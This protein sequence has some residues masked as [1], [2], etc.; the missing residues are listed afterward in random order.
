VP[1]GLWPAVL[2]A[3]VIVAGAAGTAVGWSME[4]VARGLAGAGAAALLFPVWHRT[5]RSW[6]R[7]LRGAGGG[8]LA[9]AQ[10]AV[11]RACCAVPG[12]SPSD[13]R[14]QGGPPRRPPLLRPAWGT[15]A[16]RGQGRF[17]GAWWLDAPAAAPSRRPALQGLG[18]T[19]GLGALLVALALAPAVARWSAVQGM[20][21]AGALLPAGFEVHLTLAEQLRLGA[22]VPARWPPEA[23]VPLAGQAA[24]VDAAALAQAPRG[25]PLLLAAAGSLTGW[26]AL[27]LFWPL[28]LVVWGAALAAQEVYFRQVAGLRGRW[29]ALACLLAVLN[30]PAWWCLA[31]GALEFL[32]LL[33]WG[34]A[35]AV[36]LVAGPPQWRRAG[37][38]S[39]GAVLCLASA[40]LLGA[41]VVLTL[42]IPGRAPPP[43]VLAATGVLGTPVPDLLRHQVPGLAPAAAALV[44]ALPF[45]VLGLLALAGAARRPTWAARLT[46]GAPPMLV[47]LGTL[48][49]WRWPLGSQE[50]DAPTQGWLLLG[51]SAFVLIGAAVRAISLEATAEGSG[52]RPHLPR[53]AT[54][55]L[56]TRAK[57]R[58][59]PAAGGGRHRPLCFPGRALR[60]GSVALGVALPV[61]LLDLALV[62][63]P[64]VDL[65]T[66]AVPLDP[67]WLRALARAVPPGARVVV[68][69]AFLDQPALA[70]TQRAVAVLIAQVL[71]GRTV[72][73]PVPPLGEALPAVRRGAPAPPDPAPRD[74]ARYWLGPP[75]ADAGASADAAETVVWQ[76]PLGVLKRQSQR[77]WTLPSEWL[78]R[79]QRITRATPFVLEAGAAGV[80]LRP[81]QDTVRLGPAGELAQ[82]ALTV[83]S[84]RDQQLFVEAH[85]T[86]WALLLQAGIN[87]VVT[88]A[89]IRPAGATIRVQVYPDEIA[90]LLA[91]EGRTR[92]E[93][94]GGPP[95]PG[96]HTLLEGP[97]ALFLAAAA[98]RAGAAA[99]LTLDFHSTVAQAQWDVTLDLTPGGAFARGI[100]PAR[101]VAQWQVPL[102]QQG[103]QVVAIEL[104]PDGRVRAS[105]NGLPFVP[106][107]TWEERAAGSY[108][109][110]AVLWQRGIPV[111]RILLG[112][113]TLL[114]GQEALAVEPV[115][116]Y[117]LLQRV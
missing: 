54:S 33:A 37:G 1:G 12:R 66:A 39:S 9:R 71:A 115:N 24:G 77:G 15:G 17:P 58:G 42:G 30:P 112:R 53:G 110:W 101:P 111:G 60:W 70:G 47:G 62:Q 4:Q 2:L 5:V 61:V 102:A 51:L 82:L 67:A 6:L 105:T 96:A 90:F 49:C 38:R 91:V 57:G 92:A 3:L 21:P 36:V 28:T 72:L 108:D 19:V 50:I 83:Y 79:T 23:L 87:R 35:L 56:E 16:A 25:V 29:L 63:A 40:V 41:A 109:L 59:R 95:A 68:S 20:V 46:A 14:S 64:P 107:R 88:P 55:G 22:P 65:G 13:C 97:P 94:P 10:R 78:G 52:R 100:D 44:P 80:L 18:G 11:R 73:A 85:Y 106:W 43:P 8:A 86:R 103:Y 48:A 89:I 114:P 26:T 117:L 75:G 84:P 45:G 31:V 7:R 69:P 76:T 74:A 98:D 27:E 116:G 99:Y 32:V 113:L 93:P 81:R 104:A 34:P